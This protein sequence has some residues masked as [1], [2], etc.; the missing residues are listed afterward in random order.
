MDDVIKKLQTPE[1]CFRSSISILNDNQLARGQLILKWGNIRTIKS[2][3]GITE[4][5]L[6]YG[7]PDQKKRQKNKANRT[8]QM[9]QRQ[10][11]RRS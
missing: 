9:V 5:Y 6:A 7:N 2:G 4:S 1:D 8:W 3:E 10:D 11:Q